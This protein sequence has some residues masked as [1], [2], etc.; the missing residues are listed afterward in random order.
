MMREVRS[1]LRTTDTRKVRVTLFCGTT[2]DP[3][4]DAIGQPLS[5]VL[6]G[7]T[8]CSCIEFYVRK[9]L[10]KH[11]GCLLNMLPTEESQSCVHLLLAVALT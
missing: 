10:S 1:L 8:T 4:Q 5:F 6:D 9:I 7:M 2:L 11:V 3:V